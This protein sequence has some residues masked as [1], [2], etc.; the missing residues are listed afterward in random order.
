MTQYEK[1]QVLAS[2]SAEELAEEA[3]VCW[4]NGYGSHGRHGR[5]GH[6]H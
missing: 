3:A 6:R 1:P 2:Y 4:F 5:H